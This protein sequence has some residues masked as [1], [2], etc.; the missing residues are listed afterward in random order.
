[1][2]YSYIIYEQKGPTAQITLNRPDKLNSF[3]APMAEEF[4]N[5][6]KECSNNDD[7]RCLLITGN[8]RAFCSGQD[9]D[10]ALKNSEDDNSELG[11]IVRSSYNP[12]ILGIRH[13]EKPVVCAVNGVAAGAG[14]NIAL[15]CDF[16]LAAVDANFIQS[17]SNIGLIPDSGG[18]FLLPRLI[19]MAQ[20]NRL[21]M[22]GDKITAKEAFEIGLIYGVCEADQLINE[23]RALADRLSAMPTRAF[24]L[25]K[26]GLNCSIFNGLEQQLEL[27]AKLQTAAGKTAD[28]HEGIRAFIEKRKPNFKGK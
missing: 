12:I 24:G 22:L 27:E 5:A 23:A 17:F 1:M 11:D 14:A 2:A 16:V 8:G 25:L 6:L 10:E 20:T 15:A 3:T 7:I 28:Y 9:L 4:Q 18:T 26:R 21:L 19:G 13:L